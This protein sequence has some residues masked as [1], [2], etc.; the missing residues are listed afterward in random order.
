M[1]KRLIDGDALWK[2]KKVRRLDPEY[3]AEYMWL[4]PLAEANGCFELD[5]E[6]IW[7]TCYAL[8]RPDWTSQHVHN[9]LTALEQQKLLFA[10]DY[11]NK[12]YGFWVGME[13]AGRLPAPSD[14]K[15]Y[16]NSEKIVPLE[17][18][19]TFLEQD[20]ES[21]SRDYREVIAIFPR[22]SNAIAP[23]I[24][25]GNGNGIGNG[26]GS[27]NGAGASGISITSNITPNGDIDASLDSSSSSKPQTPAEFA[28]YL[29][30]YLQTRIDSGDDVTLLKS[31]R[32]LFAQDFKTLLELGKTPADIQAVIDMSQV[33]AQ[34]LYYKRSSPLLTNWDRLFALVQ[35]LRRNPNRASVKPSPSFAAPSS[36]GPFVG[37]EFDELEG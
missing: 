16:K 20:I 1:P 13:K 27:G 9:L 26:V 10:F 34:R 12:R 22:S 31:W 14:K 33:P 25:I 32:T 28:D 37:E 36:Q 8:A 11:E 4:L 3:R 19:A 5:A 35:A 30:G 18:L 2:S 15:K 24:A 6:V 17:A 7:A 23:A 21:V 29:K